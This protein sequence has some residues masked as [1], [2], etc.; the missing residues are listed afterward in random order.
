MAGTGGPID[1]NFVE[2][3][4]PPYW[5]YDVLQAMRVLTLVPGALEDARADDAFEL[6]DQKR[7]DDGTWTTDARWWDFPG[8]LPNAYDPREGPGD[9]REAVDWSQTADEMV[10]LNALI[11][12]KAGGRT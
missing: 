4:W 8:M 1:Q 2:L 7:M 9:G 11:S 3:H 10:T 12:L 6:L 5:R